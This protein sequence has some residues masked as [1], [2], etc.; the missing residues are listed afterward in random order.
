MSQAGSFST[1]GGGGGTPV[2]K[3]TGNIGLPVPADGSNNINVLG[4]GVIVTTGNPGTNTIT[5]AFTDE[6]AQQFDAD[7]GSAVPVAGIINII[8][9]LNVNTLGFGDT[10]TIS[11]SQTPL[12]NN[13]TDVTT[14]PYVVLST[15]YYLSVDTSTIAITIQLP[16]APAPFRSFIIK[17]RSGNAVVRNITVTTPGGIVLIDGAASQIMN[18]NYQAMQIMFNGTSYEIF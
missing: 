5:I 11:A 17:D 13:Y 18:T 1:S 9:G 10:I 15:D 4:S 12:I 6:V 2:E 3:L 7:L 8:G 16:N 14:S